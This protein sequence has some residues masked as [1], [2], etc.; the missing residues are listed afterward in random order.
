MRAKTS[1]SKGLG[2]R[3]LWVPFQASPL[4]S[5]VS[6]A[7]QLTSGA[8]P[9]KWAYSAPPW[10]GTQRQCSKAPGSHTEATITK[11]P[12]QRARG[13]CRGKLK[14]QECAKSKGTFALIW[15]LLGGSPFGC[16]LKAWL[17]FKLPTDPSGEEAGPEMRG[18][19]I[20]RCNPTLGSKV[21]K[22]GLKGREVTCPRSL[23]E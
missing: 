19:E 23:R 6:S 12:E 20:P 14:R 1:Q 22:V 3:S 2:V 8:P 21:P 13:K 5:W 18:Q 4:I 11:G 7:S 15:T 16:F 10:P 9:V 17:G